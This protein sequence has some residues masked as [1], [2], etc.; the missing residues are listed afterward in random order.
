[1]YFAQY[2]LVAYFIRSKLC[3][4]SPYSY[5]TPSTFPVSAGHAVFTLQFFISY[6]DLHRHC[7]FPLSFWNLPA[8][9]GKNM[10]SAPPS[11]GLKE[12]NLSPAYWLGSMRLKDCSFKP[13][14]LFFFFFWFNF[15]FEDLKNTSYTF[16][17]P[18]RFL[19]ESSEDKHFFLIGK[20]LPP[21]PPFKKKLELI[22]YKKGPFSS[23]TW[24]GSIMK[25]NIFLCSLFH[26][27]QRNQP[28]S[29]QWGRPRREGSLSTPMDAWR[30]RVWRAGA[31]GADLVGPDVW[32]LALLHVVAVGTG[33]TPP[34]GPLGP[35]HN[36]LDS[37]Q[38]RF[39]Y[40]VL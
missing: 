16:H 32:S 27:C 12:Q 20:K 34:C 1:M 14:S 24:C 21:N 31:A 17:K 5:F 15:T 23:I 10:P 26:A 3:F 13:P 11:L 40:G 6:V 4:L 36:M 28:M 18:Y 25:K 2:V 7:G 22:Q 29:R 30:G 39:L 8:P 19:G 9:C 37:E 35:P 33:P 38:Q